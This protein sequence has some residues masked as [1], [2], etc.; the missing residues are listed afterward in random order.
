MCGLVGAGTSRRDLE[1]QHVGPDR[2]LSPGDSRL[3]PV[4]SRQLGVAATKAN[5]AWSW[6]V[7]G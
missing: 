6:P 4:L 1:Q 7:A 2:L 3:C 5:C